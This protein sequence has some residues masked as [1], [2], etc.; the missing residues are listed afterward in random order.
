MKDD[1]I[2]QLLK[3]NHVLKQKLG[4]YRK[5][6]TENEPKKNKNQTMT[7]I[8]MKKAGTGTNNIQSD[9]ELSNRPTSRTRPMSDQGDDT[10]IQSAAMCRRHTNSL[11][12]SS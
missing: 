8:I 7:N 2:K 6:T 4:I 10:H 1:Y 9:S 11:S 5:L 12:E 3:E